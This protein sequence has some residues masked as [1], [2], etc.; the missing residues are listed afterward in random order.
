MLTTSAHQPNSRHSCHELLMTAITTQTTIKSQETPIR[1]AQFLLAL[2]LQLVEPL[3]SQVAY[4]FIPQLIR[5]IGVTNGDETRVGF[6]VGLM[7]RY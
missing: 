7:V 2:F 1:W 3:S 6:C 5:E 4:L